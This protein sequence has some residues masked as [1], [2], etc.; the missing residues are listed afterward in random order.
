[1]DLLWLGY[2]GLAVRYVD[3]V[4]VLFYRPD[5]DGRI[6][7]GYGRVPTNVRAVVVTS[8]GVFWPSSWRADQLRRR[9]ARWRRRRVTSDE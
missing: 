2:D 8:D 4:A 7:R 9:W 1:M 3:V 6:I 5:L